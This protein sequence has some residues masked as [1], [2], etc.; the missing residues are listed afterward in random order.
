MPCHCAVVAF[1]SVTCQP[2]IQKG[3][4]MFEVDI[5][6]G[7]PKTY[8]RIFIR[9]FCHDYRCQHISKPS[10]LMTMLNCEKQGMMELCEF[11]KLKTSINKFS[12]S[13]IYSIILSGFVLHHMVSAISFPK[14]A[15]S[16]HVGDGCR[17]RCLPNS[18]RIE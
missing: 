5:Y 13:L 15:P 9:A 18:E 2:K 4:G 10:M 16:Y 17:W 1:F 3:A 14:C 6:K 8:L 12:S 7:W 11:Q